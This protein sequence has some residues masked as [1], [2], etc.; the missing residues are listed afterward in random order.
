MVIFKQGNLN[1]LTA[2]NY[3]IVSLL[4]AYIAIKKLY[5]VC[6]SET[7]LDS[8]YLCDDDD[9]DDDDDDELFLWYG[10]PTKSIS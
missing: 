6:V 8:F 2:Y 7:Y 1:G 4:L 5:V 3:L 9:D 10:L